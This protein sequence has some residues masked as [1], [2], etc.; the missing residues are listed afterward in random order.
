MDAVT[1]VNGLGLSDTAL[2]DERG[3]I[4]RGAQTLLVA[5]ASLDLLRA[6]GR[7][8]SEMADIE[9]RPH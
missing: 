9:K 7:G 1:H 6:G 8:L 4:G 3:R 5:P 2:W